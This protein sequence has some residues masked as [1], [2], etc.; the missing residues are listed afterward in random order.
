ME[1]GIEPK[2]L[3]DG[4]HMH[5]A[6]KDGQEKAAELV[7]LRTV[8]AEAAKTAKVARES[9]DAA[10]EAAKTAAMASV[11]STATAEATPSAERLRECPT[12]QPSIIKFQSA[13]VIAQRRTLLTETQ[14]SLGGMMSIAEKSASVSLIETHSVTQT[15]VCVMC[16]LSQS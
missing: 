5:L 10:Q 4:K 7:R 16:C 15:D 12:P 11:P 6:G 13:V 2:F 9:A 3:S 14:S 8:A 1:Q